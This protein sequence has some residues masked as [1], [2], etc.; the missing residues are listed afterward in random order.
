MPKEKNSSMLQLVKKHALEVPAPNRY[1]PLKIVKIKGG[2]IPEN[3]KFTI[4]ESIAYD[5]KSIPAPDA[6]RS[7]RGMAQVSK[8]RN[9]IR[10]KSA[11]ICHKQKEKPYPA[12]GGKMTDRSFEVIHLRSRSSKFFKAKRN[13]YIE[14]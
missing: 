13:T 11:T 12:P 6:Y 7:K 1:K 2:T 5:K 10:V 9:K 14:Q 8:E 4:I 3:P